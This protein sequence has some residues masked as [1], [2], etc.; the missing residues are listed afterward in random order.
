MSNSESITKRR[1]MFPRQMLTL[2]MAQELMNNRKNF[3][4]EFF[5]QQ[6]IFFI[7]QIEVEVHYYSIDLSDKNSLA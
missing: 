1:I 3:D 2:S 5:T 7:S 6:M 4:D